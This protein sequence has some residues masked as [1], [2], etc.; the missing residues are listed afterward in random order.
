MQI[1]SFTPADTEA[2]LAIWLEASLQ[3]HHF[4]DPAYWHANLA[5]MRET[6]LPKDRFYTFEGE[7][8]YSNFRRFSVSTAESLAVP[9]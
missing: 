7:A 6:Y 2:V 8:T 1:R 3:A 4:I 5:P 9:K